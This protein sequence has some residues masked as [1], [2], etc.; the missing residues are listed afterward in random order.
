MPTL[1]RR[2]VLPL[3]AGGL[4]AACGPRGSSEPTPTPRTPAQQQL[5]RGLTWLL[6]QQDTDGAFPSQTYGLMKGGESLTPLVLLA[7]L[8]TVPHSPVDLAPSIRRGLDFLE[9]I[10]GPDGSIGLSRPVADY[11]VYASAM[12]VRAAARFRSPAQLGAFATTLSWLKARQLT[13]AGGWADHSAAGGWPMGA[14]TP[15]VP[16]RAGHV[17]LSMTRRALQAFAA[18]DQPLAPAA[19]Q[20]ALDFLSRAQLADG[21]FVYSPVTPQL[22]KAGEAASYGSPTCDGLLALAAL[23]RGPGDEQ[24]DRALAFLRSIH[25]VDRNPG[26][27]GGPFAAFS[28]A[29]KGY[30]RAASAAVFSRYGWAEGQAGELVAAVLADQAEDGA[31]RSTELLQKE[32]DP[33]VS[34]AFALQALAASMPPS[35]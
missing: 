10:A 26:I 34:T 11:P 22:N 32:D 35:G 9:G 14:R 24:V 18:A 31:W 17:D 30:Y 13:T 8:D 3:L 28:T 7:L 2:A 4:A 19:A 5:D 6:A 29:M 15:P 16:P 20:D 27:D 33:L 21:G 1:T 12:A 23:G 25:R